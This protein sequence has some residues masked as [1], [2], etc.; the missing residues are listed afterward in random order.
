[1]LDRADFIGHR[2]DHR[3]QGRGSHAILQ[4]RDAHGV[5]QLPVHEHDGAE[6]TEDAAS[7]SHSSP[8]ISGNPPLTTIVRRRG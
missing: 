6:V 1:M 7:L 8:R 5:S 2:D 4:R 3:R